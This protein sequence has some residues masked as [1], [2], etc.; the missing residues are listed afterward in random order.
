[1]FHHQ[2]NKRCCREK[3]AVT[4]LSIA[5]KTYDIKAKKYVPENVWPWLS[6]LNSLTPTALACTSF[7][8]HSL[9]SVACISCL[10][11]KRLQANKPGKSMRTNTTPDMVGSFTFFDT[12]TTCQVLRT[13]NRRKIVSHD[14]I[15]LWW[16][17]KLFVGP[18]VCLSLLVSCCLMIADLMCLLQENYIFRRIWLTIILSRVY[19]FLIITFTLSTSVQYVADKYSSLWFLMPCIILPVRSR[20]EPLF[21]TISSDINF[22]RHNKM[23]V[24]EGQQ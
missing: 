13:P 16:E 17:L 24:V 15:F 5:C 11:H 19:T 14:H 23:I 9:S 21:I 8:T 2:C 10:D 18:I 20:I 3:V 22:H 12:Q 4:I 7:S 6:H 1:M